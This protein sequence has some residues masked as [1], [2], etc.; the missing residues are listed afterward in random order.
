MKF[1]YKGP[2]PC[3]HYEGKTKHN[4]N[5]GQ[6]VES[7]Q[8][9]NVLFP[10]R[11]E[12]LDR[13]RTKILG[14]D[15]KPLKF[16]ESEAVPPADLSHPET[17][18]PAITPEPANEESGE[19]TP[20]TPDDGVVDEGDSEDPSPVLGKDVSK[21]HAKALGKT[22]LKVFKAAKG[23]GF[24]VVKDGQPTTPKPVPLK[25]LRDHIAEA[26]E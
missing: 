17:H 20:G 23:E 11:F 8:E 18:P 24:F 9:L 3:I 5:T 25:E 6:V 4:L 16:V 22:G 21:A 10:D 2:K 19:R 1:R 12:A 13:P 15:G 7:E 14:V 26:S